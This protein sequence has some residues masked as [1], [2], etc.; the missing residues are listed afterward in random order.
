MRQREKTTDIEALAVGLIVVAGIALAVV[1]RS[2]TPHEVAYGLGMILVIGLYVTRSA[3]GAK[4]EGSKLPAVVWAILGLFVVLLMLNYLYGA[5]NRPIGTVHSVETAIDPHV[6]IVPPFVISYLGLYAFIVFSIALVALY[7][8]HDQLRTLLLALII[9]T[10]TGLITFVIFQT[11]VPPPTH[12][13]SAPFRSML[14]YVENDLYAGNF[15][16]AFPSLHVAY[17]GVLAI[18][19]GRLNRP[20]LSPVMIVFAATVALSTQFLHQHFIMDLLYGLVLAAA[21]YATAWWAT[22]RQSRFYGAT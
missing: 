5:S 7:R 10:G 13:G 6:P 11:H 19:W 9:A 12:F 22:E 2:Y 3:H 4:R 17:S 8:L 1:L 14:L 15:Y 18:A 20:I 16:S 21:S